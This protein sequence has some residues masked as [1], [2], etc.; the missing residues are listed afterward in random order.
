VLFV[1][2]KAC[3][4]FAWMV[5]QPEY[6][7]SL[8]V[9]MEN[10]IDSMSEESTAGAGTAVLRPLTLA[11]FRSQ[12][13]PRPRAF[14]IPTGW[15]TDSAGFS[16]IDSGNIKA[17]IDLSLDRAALLLSKGAKVYKR[18]IFSC[19]E[20]DRSLIGTGVF[21][22][23]L[24]KDVIAYISKGIAELPT[25]VI[26]QATF[27]QI[28]SEEL[29]IMPFALLVEGYCR[30]RAELRRVKDENE[31][32]KR[33]R[34]GSVVGMPPPPKQMRISFNNGRLY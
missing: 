16:H 4:D 30:M 19:S 33:Q 12:G 32:L 6:D 20:D 27:K 1:K 22:K 24:G 13:A 7:D 34:S 14:G 31:K 2:K 18:I 28:R 15:C 26:T 11:H 5:K 8:F 29:K 25:R 10:F 23:T 3:G 9:V 17:A 21:K